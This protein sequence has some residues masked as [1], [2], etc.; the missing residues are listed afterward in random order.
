VSYEALS[1]RSAIIAARLDGTHS[2]WNSV[3][4]LF[5]NDISKQQKWKLGNEYKTLFKLPGEMSDLSGFRKKQPC[6][7]FFFMEG[8][9]HWHYP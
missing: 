2:V 1:T 6:L 9:T 8:F 5:M 7:A 3:S 4:E